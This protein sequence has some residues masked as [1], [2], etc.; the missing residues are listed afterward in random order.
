MSL[1]HPVKGLN[2]VHRGRS[3]LQSNRR[4]P[5]LILI[6]PVLVKVVVPETLSPLQQSP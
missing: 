2:Q 3:D 1:V 6:G 5:V 4:R